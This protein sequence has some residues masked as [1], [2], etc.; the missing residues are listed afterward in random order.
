MVND[1][2]TDAMQ[3]IAN[4]VDNMRFAD[5]ERRQREGAETTARVRSEVVVPSKMV[6]PSEDGRVVRPGTSEGRG[7]IAAKMILDAEKFQR[8]WQNHKVWIIFHSFLV[9][10]EKYQYKK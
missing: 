3:R 10:C 2:D 5:D 8:K 4:F 6:D 1:Q 9:V 7:K